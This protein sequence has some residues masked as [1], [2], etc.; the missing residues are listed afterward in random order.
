MKQ[1]KLGFG[2]NHRGPKGEIYFVVLARKKT[3]VLWHLETLL[4]GVLDVEKIVGDYL[5]SL[6][7]FSNISVGA[8]KYLSM[9]MTYS[10]GYLL[11]KPSLVGIDPY[12]NVV[13]GYKNLY[14]FVCM[15]LLI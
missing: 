9:C 3:K 4:I 8:E 2:R 1:G 5:L 11:E 12:I 10:F 15:Y 14:Y 13:C 6:E 7:N